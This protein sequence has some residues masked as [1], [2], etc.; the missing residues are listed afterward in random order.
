M[1]TTVRY[2]QANQMVFRGLNHGKCL[3]SIFYFP[4]CKPCSPKGTGRPTLSCVDVKPPW[5]KK[6]RF[7][8]VSDFQG[9][10]WYSCSGKWVLGFYQAYGYNFPNQSSWETTFWH[11]NQFLKS[12]CYP[13]SKEDITSFRTI[14]ANINLFPAEQQ[15]LPEILIGSSFPDLFK[16]LPLYL[17]VDGWHLCRN[18]RAP[19]C[20]PRWS[21]MSATFSSR[22]WPGYV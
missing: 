5:R 8:T 16:G 9:K 7:F 3:A 10:R 12:F 14:G 20:H 19:P 11:Q 17:P 22:H 4:G 1:V 13:W 6:L 15:F 18:S 2:L 21:R